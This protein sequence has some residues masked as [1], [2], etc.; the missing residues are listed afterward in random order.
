MKRFMPV[1]SFSVAVSLPILGLSQSFATG[2]VPETSVVMVNVEDGEGTIDV[3]NTDS[4]AALLYSS[5]ENLPEDTET[6]LI[7]TPPVTRLEAGEKQQVRFIVQSSQPITTQRLKRVSFEGIPQKNLNAGA[8]VGVTVRQNLPVIINPAR[9]AKN[10][11]PWKLLKW[12]LNSDG[13]TVK[14][15]SPY[16][17]RLSQ[18]VSLL[19]GD[20]VVSLPRTYILAGESLSIALPRSNQPVKSLRIY[21]ASAYGFQVESYETP[22]A[23]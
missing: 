7:I 20:A 6:L 2:M 21:P 16:V 9:L 19:P 18:Q 4:Q 14:N 5:L 10:S 13:L 8:T 15:D 23:N 1:V 17:I 11:E 3:T 22:L 12:H